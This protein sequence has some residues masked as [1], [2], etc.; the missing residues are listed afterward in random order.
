M[1]RFTYPGHRSIPV[2]ISNLH[3]P[4][5][6]LYRKSSSTKIYN[7]AFRPAKLNSKREQNDLSL[8]PSVSCGP[9]SGTAL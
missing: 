6:C 3:S 9:T 8:F 4:D 5:I 1:A 2:T 7:E